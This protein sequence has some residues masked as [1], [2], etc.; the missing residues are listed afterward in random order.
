MRANISKKRS[1]FTFELKVNFLTR[2]IDQIRQNKFDLKCQPDI[3]FGAI[4]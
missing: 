2:T 3:I 4:L 1:Q